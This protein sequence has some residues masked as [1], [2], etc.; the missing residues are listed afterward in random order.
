MKNPWYFL[1]FIGVLALVAGCTTPVENTVPETTTATPIET[2][3]TT[4]P[5]LATDLPEFE[6]A[7]VPVISSGDTDWMTT[8]A[9]Y[10][11]RTALRDEAARVMY[12]E[13][14]TVEG[15]LLSCHPTPL[16]SAGDGCAPALRITNQTATVDFLVD[17]EGGR[18]IAVVVEMKENV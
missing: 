10:V 11:A 15:V 12:Q 2:P 9:S 18:V 13:G 14:G 17:E 6:Y 16:P 4:R 1:L 3:V 7:E 8:N 5:A